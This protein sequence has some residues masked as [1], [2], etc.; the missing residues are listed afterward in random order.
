MWPESWVTRRRH[1]VGDAALPLSALEP[2]GG[3][4]VRTR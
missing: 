2:D 3:D 1:Q 4:D